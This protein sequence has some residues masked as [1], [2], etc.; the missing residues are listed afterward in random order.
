M[1]I[2]FDYGSEAIPYIESCS[3]K[4][5]TLSKFILE[6]NRI[7]QRK[8]IFAYLP[9]DTAFEKRVRFLEGKVI[10]EPGARQKTAEFIADF[11]KERPNHL[12]LF[13]HSLASPS[14]PWLNKANI[15]FFTYKSEVYPFLTSHDTDLDII[16]NML[17]RTGSYPSI[18]ILTVLSSV[19]NIQD[20][21]DVDETVLE[22]LATQLQYIIVGAYDEETMLFWRKD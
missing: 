2:K 5:K 19:Q 6:K 16:Q 18:G 22:N 10:D 1:L 15:K 20:R 11:I 21:Q 14:D 9:T 12:A 7:D 17:R 3:F 8:E 13:E 4:G